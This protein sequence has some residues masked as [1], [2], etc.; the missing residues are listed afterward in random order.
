MG[1]PDFTFIKCRSFSNCCVF[2]YSNN[3]HLYES[4]S[5]AYKQNAIFVMIKLSLGLVK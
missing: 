3:W 5:K 1:D 2:L 4:F